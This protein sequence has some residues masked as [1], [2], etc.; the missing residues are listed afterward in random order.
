MSNESHDSGAGV[1]VFVNKHGV[2]DS[3]RWLCWLS[4]LAAFVAIVAVKDPTQHL[5]AIKDKIFKT[6]SRPAK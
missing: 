5:G 3:L 4:A 1:N 2:G 6:S